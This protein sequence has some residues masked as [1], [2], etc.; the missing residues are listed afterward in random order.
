MSLDQ[1]KFKK[2][3]SKLFE[4]FPFLAIC[5]NIFANFT[6]VIKVSLEIIE[7]IGAIYD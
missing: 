5:L 6:V 4:L 1:L 2:N 3:V 7:N